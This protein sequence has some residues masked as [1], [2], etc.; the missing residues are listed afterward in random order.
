MEKK[1]SSKTKNVHDGHRA[2]MKEKIL[3]GG[4][5]ALPDH[6][7]LETLLFYCIPRVNTNEQA[8]GL[9]DYFGSVESIVNATPEELSNVSG[10]K[11]ESSI[12]ICLIGELIRRI[13][14]DACREP[15]SYDK[16]DKVIQYMQHRFIGDQVEKIYLLLFDNGMKLI[17]CTCISEG[18]VN[19]AQFIPSSIVSHAVLKKASAVMLA[20]N[21][22][23]GVAI[24]SGE[25][26][27][28]TEFLRRLLDMLDIYFIDHILFAGDRYVSVL[29]YYPEEPPL[30]VNDSFYEAYLER[31][32]DKGKPKPKT[33]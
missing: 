9:L 32:K 10:I 1:E 8:H 6:E 4:A 18:T 30:K 21:H 27:E 19:Q 31:N 11:K 3:S 17:E 20:H 28:A 14:R 22:P 29:N 24:P 5:A 26:I 13:A 23:G 2:R 12:L 15:T 25:D 16:M 7:L 33:K